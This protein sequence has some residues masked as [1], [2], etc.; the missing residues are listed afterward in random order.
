MREGLYRVRF[1]TREDEGSG[2]A[3]LRDGRFLGGDSGMS[4]VGRYSLAEDRFE[5]DLTIAT[6]TFVGWMMPV[7]LSERASIR[8]AGRVE[9]D[10]ITMGGEADTPSRTRLDV[11]MEFLAA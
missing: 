2:V 5:A 9:A 4:Y 1:R 11:E 6:H 10:R 3:V 7:L 8:L